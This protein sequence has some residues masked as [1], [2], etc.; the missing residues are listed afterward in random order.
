[1]QCLF[2]IHRLSCFIDDFYTI[3]V[4][5]SALLFPNFH[6]HMYLYRINIYIHRYIKFC[7]PISEVAI[8]F[9]QKKCCFL[10]FVLLFGA[11]PGVFGQM[12]DF[13]IYWLLSYHFSL[14]ET[15]KHFQKFI[16]SE[17][18][19]VYMCVWRVKTA[20]VDDVGSLSITHIHTNIWCDPNKK[21]INDGRSFGWAITN[22][23]F[24]N[25]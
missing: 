15:T 18:W 20:S 21:F 10:T 17:M 22:C 9:A 13:I 14:C 3:F 23:A 5:C 11:P 25:N 6:S 4:I 19:I 12:V 7:V 1:M 2:I 24:L 8:E 16:E